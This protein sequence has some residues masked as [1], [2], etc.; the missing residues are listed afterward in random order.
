MYKK[1]LIIFLLSILFFSCNQNKIEQ[2]NT[3]ASFNQDKIEQLNN[4]ISILN[5]KIL[6]LETEN[7]KL[8][9]EIDSYKT[10]ISELRKIFD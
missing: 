10:I 6:L 1:L 7:K 9:E 4:E 2:L 8:T 3:E 5:N